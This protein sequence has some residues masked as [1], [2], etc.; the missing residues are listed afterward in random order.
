MSEKYYIVSE[1]DGVMHCQLKTFKTLKEARNESDEWEEIC[2]SHIAI[3]SNSKTPS[4]PIQSRST[5]WNQK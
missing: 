1:F 4:K 5:F 3:I 2:A